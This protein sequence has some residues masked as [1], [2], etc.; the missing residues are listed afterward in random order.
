[1]AAR[2]FM[3]AGCYCII[4]AVQ[5]DPEDQLRHSEAVHQQ[6]QAARSEE[7]QR[8]AVPA[9]EG[10]PADDSVGSPADRGTAEAAAVPAGLSGSEAGYRAEL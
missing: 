5:R 10:A 6:V 8:Q 7:V 4:R 3:R 1:M 2:R 9:A